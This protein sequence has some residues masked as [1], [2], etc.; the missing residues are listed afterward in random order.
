LLQTAQPEFSDRGK[1]AHLL[2][3]IFGWAAIFIMN[4]ELFKDISGHDGRYQVSN[5]GRVRS[6]HRG[7]NIILKPGTMN[8]FGHCS[9]SLR[10]KTRT[11]HSLVLEAFIGPPPPNMEVLHING[12]GS[13]NR[14]ENL[15][16]GTRSENNLDM[17]VHGRLY[18]SVEDIKYIREAKGKYLAE[19]LSIKY[20]CSK[21]MIYTIRARKQYAH[22]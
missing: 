13:D 15:R 1:A 6:F 10:R 16:Y 17:A 7:K 12:V 21:S 8:K 19:T 2:I 5:L 22:V 4:T 9:V 20:K 3:Q 14:L 11:V 18:F